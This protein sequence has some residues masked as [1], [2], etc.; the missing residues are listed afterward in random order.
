MSQ[1]PTLTLKQD[2]SN[3]AGL[4]DKINM[5]KSKQCGTQLYNKQY[6]TQSRTCQHVC[7]C[8]Q[9]FNEVRIRYYRNH[10]YRSVPDFKRPLEK[11]NAGDERLPFYLRL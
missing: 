2:N 11:P 10:S 7:V 4:A 6:A 9:V 8:I 1:K 5:K 3:L